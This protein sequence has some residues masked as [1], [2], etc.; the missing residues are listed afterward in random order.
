MNK[1]F[2]FFIIFIVGCLL[3][4]CNLIKQYIPSD[5]QYVVWDN[6]YFYYDHYRCQTDLRNEE[7]LLPKIEH[8]GKTYKI[9][10]SKQSVFKDEKLHIICWLEETSNKNEQINFSS[11]SAYIIYSFIDNKIEYFIKWDDISVQEILEVNDDYTIIIANH[12]DYNFRLLKIDVNNNTVDTFEYTDD[13]WY[14]IYAADGYIAFKKGEEILIGSSKD[15]TFKPLDHQIK[16]ETTSVKFKTIAINNR[17]LL[18]IVEE[19]NIDIAGYEAKIHM[20]TYYDFN[21]EK[22]Y[23]VVKYEDK[24]HYSKNNSRLESLKYQE[25]FILGEPTAVTSKE[26]NQEVTK[27]ENLNNVLYSITFDGEDINLDEKFIFQKNYQYHIARQDE[28]FIVISYSVSSNYSIRYKYLDIKNYTEIDLDDYEDIFYV[29]S[30]GDVKY[31]IKTKY[32]TSLYDRITY[33]YLFR[34]DANDNIGLLN[35]FTSHDSDK[36]KAQKFINLVHSTNGKIN[37]LTKT[38]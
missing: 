32:Q 2:R 27:I 9:Y 13:K 30:A 26:N 22:F 20:L 23:E 25:L 14:Y 5:D 36:T 35:Y 21:S 10:S 11:T 38:G 6:N 7:S 16:P 8:N 4:S 29:S 17:N 31:I 19:T 33:Y 28:M 24:K 12:S 3:T 34:I 15:F 1:L 37:I 18:Q